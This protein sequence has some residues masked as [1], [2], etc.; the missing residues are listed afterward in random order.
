MSGTGRKATAKTATTAVTV[1]HRPLSQ[2]KTCS[3]AKDDR[4][5]AIAYTG[6]VNATPDVGFTL[7]PYFPRLVSRTV[8][9]AGAETFQHEA[10]GRLT[11]D[12]GVFTLGYFGQ[13]GQIEAGGHNIGR[14]G[15]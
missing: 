8:Q 14:T 10:I 12:L 13:T 4:L 3:Y 6:A 15:V 11:G 7:D 1:K 9:E 2:V 5:T